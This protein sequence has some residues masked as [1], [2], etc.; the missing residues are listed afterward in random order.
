M[1]VSQVALNNLQIQTLKLF[2]VDRRYFVR[3]SPIVQFD[4][5]I[6]QIIYEQ[7]GI[8]Y[9]NT[10]EDHIEKENLKAVLKLLNLDQTYFQVVDD[11][12]HCDTQTD[13]IEAILHKVHNRW[14]L[15]QL[16]DSVNGKLYD[17]NFDSL[18]EIQ[19]LL[20][21]EID[22]PDEEDHINL[23]LEAYGD[24]EGYNWPCAK[25]QERLGPLPVQTH[26]LIAAPVEAGKTAMVTNCSLFFRSQGATVLHLNNEDPKRKLLERYYIN[27]F[28]EPLEVIN[29]RRQEYSKIFN[30]AHD[31]GLVVV[32]DASLTS[33]QVDYLIRRC[34][35]DVVFIDQ[36][37]HLARD[38]EA[39]TLERLYFKLRQIAKKR[40]TRLISVTQASDTQGPYITLRDLHNS[41][42]GK[43]SQLD[44]LM[45]IFPPEHSPGFRNI[46]FPKNKLTGD[47]RC[48]TLKFNPLL[49]RY[50]D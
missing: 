36:S 46:S 1:K 30:D 41:K 10:S 21:A 15:L 49:L 26:G 27:F 4:D 48:C 35:P 9:Q 47:H 38:S 40:E 25:I 28:N 16:R 29:N 2:C 7:I 22:A 5:S 13:T 39:A 31:G 11:I 17:N 6:L 19:E 44:W 45:G 34:K 33:F 3:Y 23:E 12:Y 32:D 20:T 50:E 14:L 18:E 37:D 8:L 42:V 24:V 43:Q